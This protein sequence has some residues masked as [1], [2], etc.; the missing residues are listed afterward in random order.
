MPLK[1]IPI[2]PEDLD[3]CCS[4]HYGAYNDNPFFQVLYPKGHTN[5][6][7][8]N[9]T[10]HD[11]REHKDPHVH[12]FCVIDT[13]SKDKIIGAAKWTVVHP[14][15]PSGE[16]DEQGH[17]PPGIPD[18]DLNAPFFYHFLDVVQPLRKIHQTRKTIV[19]SD[20][21]VLEGHRHQGAGRLLVKTLIDF[22]DKEGLP[23]YL[24]STPKGYNMYKQ[25][26]FR[27]VDKLEMDLGQWKKGL[28]VYKLAL[29]YRDAGESSA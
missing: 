22:A 5:D 29:M 28:D 18:E 8:K 9:L 11:R 15:V 3:T 21:S 14:G 19:L 4:I 12:M 6:L 26:G 10:Y 24:E 27:D 17:D 20:L 23:C 7:Q 16:Q 25:L 1:V 13:A 2:I